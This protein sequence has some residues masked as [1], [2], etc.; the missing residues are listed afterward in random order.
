MEYTD[1]LLVKACVLIAG[2]FVWGFWCGNN[3]LDLT[4]QPRKERPDTAG[5][6]PQDQ[7]APANRT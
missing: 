1:Y 6:E 3:G 5:Q 2:A 4:G 7:S